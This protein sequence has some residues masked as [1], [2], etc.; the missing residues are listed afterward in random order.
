VET[1]EGIR[2]IKKEFPKVKTVLGISN[3]SFGLPPAGREVL[4]SVFLH[5]CVQAGLD[6]ALVNTEKLERYPSIPEEEKK[7]V[8]DLLWNRGKDP[9]AA[10]AAHFRKATSRIKKK[11]SDLS[12]DERLA[13]YIL[14]GSKEGLVEDINEKLKEVKPLEVINGP[15]MAGMDE[16]GRLFNNNELI[17]AEVL[18][19]AE[20]MKAAVAHLEP[21]MEKTE[22]TTRGKVILATVKGDVHDIGKNLVDIIL[23]NNG[24]TVVNLGIKIPPEQLIQ[25]IEEHEPDIVGLSGLLV[26]SAKQMV[27]TAEDLSKHGIKKPILV[28]GAALSEKFTDKKIARAYE[29]FVT[30]APD[31]MA[32]LSLVKRIQDPHLFAEL[33]REVSSRKK[34]GDKE[35]EYVAVTVP[36]TPEVRSSKVE[37]LKE[38]PQPPDFK[39]HVIANTPVEQIW[40]FLNPLMLFG[41]HLGIKGKTVKLLQKRD[42]QAVKKEEGGKK[43]LEIWEVVKALKGEAKGLIKP[44]AVFQFFHAG[45]QGNA[46]L[47]FDPQGKALATMN[48]PRRPEKDGLCLADY[49]SPL[50]RGEGQARQTRP[51]GPRQTGALDNKQRGEGE[52]LDNLG[53]FV[54]T[55]GEGVRE[56][57]EKWKNEGEYLKS[58][59]L[60]V[61]A[62]ETAEAYAEFLHGRLRNMWGF[63]D[64][65]HMTMVQRFQAKY[66]G[67]RYS[68]GYPAC[69]DLEGQKIIWD[70]LEPEKIGVELTEGFMMDPEAS[71]SALVFHHPQAEYFSVGAQE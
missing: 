65:V 14:E 21:M 51:S 62:L 13:N 56:L 2:A 5:Y 59:A 52:V 40:E 16:V 32:G 68:F 30:Y 69:P 9:I 34:E 58:H 42:Y 24:F 48:F 15:L 47:T 36:E 53:I 6:L 45:G 22:V 39:R 28:G 11:K 44:K 43:A 18:Q 64:P 19:S 20:A 27:I 60:Q 49:I 37:V 17:V 66:R 50:P 57:A 7:L 33:K 46:I 71:V 54:V 8:D 31:A 67:T 3:V 12:L 10:F 26:K 61:L 29:G 1:I 38:F 23:S 4:N 25:A 35:E 63:P 55:A 41:R 70:L